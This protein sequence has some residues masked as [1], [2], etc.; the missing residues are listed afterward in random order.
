MQTFAD[1]HG[2]KLE[3]APSG[4][5]VRHGGP[6][7]E[8]LHALGREAPAQLQH[9]VWPQRRAHCP[10][11]GLCGI[12]SWPRRRARAWRLQ[13]Q[14]VEVVQHA[15]AAWRGDCSHAYACQVGNTQTYGMITWWRPLIKALAP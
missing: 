4:A 11:A 2:N 10:G 8:R 12:C 1:A 3:H 9:R 5:G 6:L 14:V 15:R 13:Q 7:E